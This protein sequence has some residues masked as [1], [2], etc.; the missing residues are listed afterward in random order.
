[1]SSS[2]CHPYAFARNAR[3]RR[4]STREERRE[5]EEQEEDEEVEPGES[6]GDGL[7]SVAVVAMECPQ[8]QRLLELSYAV[9]DGQDS[10]PLPLL[11][12]FVV[13]ITVG[14]VTPAAEAARHRRE[15]RL[16]ARCAPAPLRC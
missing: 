7:R 4:S 2:A 5:G 6:A 15:A 8:R 1:M 14:S 3:K 16:R 11:V 12:T 9:R 10:V 13:I